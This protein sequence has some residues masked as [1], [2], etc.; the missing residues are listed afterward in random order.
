M[1]K[2]EHN[3]YVSEYNYINK[4]KIWKDAFWVNN[5]SFTGNSGGDAVSGERKKWEK[6]K[7]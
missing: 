3:L 2:T 6:R 1:K 7:E 5:R 4:E